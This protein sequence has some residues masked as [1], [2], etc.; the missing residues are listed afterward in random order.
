MYA[1]ADPPSRFP[2]TRNR[3]SFF[4]PPI[5]A[6][7]LLVPGAGCSAHRAVTS[8]FATLLEQN[9]FTMYTPFRA[10]D[11][12]GTIFVLAPNERGDITEFTL[13]TPERTFSDRVDIDRLLQIKDAT[14]GDRLT[15]SRTFRASI[16]VDL[17]SILLDAELLA[18]Y[19]EAVTIELGTPQRVLVLPREQVAQNRRE[20][21]DSTLASLRFYKERDA[22]QSTY[23][24]LEVLEVKSLNAVGTLKSE[25]KGKVTAKELEPIAKLET[26]VSTSNDSTFNLS[27]DKPLYIGYK[28]SRITDTLLGTAVSATEVELPQVPA[29][30]I[31]AIKRR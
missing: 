16:A 14:I 20:L 2:S 30:V 27:F 1:S 3:T 23:L 15:T 11:R 13:S 22:L 17:L 21:R 12:P 26:T 25:W 29:S 19:A 7:L 8:E 28:A 5:L 4:A 24:V 18:K 31:G 10:Q 9:G 6:L